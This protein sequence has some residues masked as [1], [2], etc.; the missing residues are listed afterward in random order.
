MQSYIAGRRTS[1]YILS[2]ISLRYLS[3][4]KQSH[5]NFRSRLHSTKLKRVENCFSVSHFKSKFQNK[6][7]LINGNGR[8]KSKMSTAV[9]YCVKKRKDLK[10]FFDGHYTRTCNF[11]C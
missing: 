2:D 11:P 5:D 10:N 8:T 7:G 6:R 1:C 9:M 4:V 3:T